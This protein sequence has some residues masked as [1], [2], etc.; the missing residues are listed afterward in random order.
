MFY[1]LIAA[2]ALRLAEQQNTSI[3]DEDD[4][5]DEDFHLASTKVLSMYNMIV[6]RFFV[7]DLLISNVTLSCLSRGNEQCSNSKKG[8][9][10]P[11]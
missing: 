3:V 8:I 5:D 1:F 11:A 4:E 2:Y 9:R 6:M 7:V 10:R